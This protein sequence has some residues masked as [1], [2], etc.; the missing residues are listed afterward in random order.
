MG[1]PRI[2]W[3]FITFASIGL[4][5]LLVSGGGLLSAADFVPL[6]NRIEG[7]PTLSEK[8][9]CENTRLKIK[10]AWYQ[11]IFSHLTV[12]LLLS[13]SLTHDKRSKTSVE[14]KRWSITANRENTRK[15]FLE[16]AMLKVCKPLKILSLAMGTQMSTR[17]IALLLQHLNHRNIA[18]LVNSFYKDNKLYLALEVMQDNLNNII[19]TQ[20]LKSD[21]IRYIIYQILSGVNYLHN[22]GITHGDLKP[23]DIGIDKDF[24][25]KIIDLNVERP[26]ETDYVLTKWFANGTRDF[27]WR[28]L[29]VNIFLSGIGLPSFYLRGKSRQRK[30]TRGA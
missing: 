17:K 6:K 29:K 19:R 24:S 28:S 20:R 27:N 16:L 11:N 26:K 15:A 14:I 21:D 8:V 18:R 13:S 9:S 4:R 1:N 10:F 23:S 25:I 12:D 22:S 30:L 2:L 3:Q 5:N 7:G